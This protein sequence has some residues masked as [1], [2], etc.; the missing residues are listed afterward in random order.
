MFGGDVSISNSAVKN[1]V[2]FE[3]NDENAEYA[4]DGNQ[5]A[6]ASNLPLWKFYSRHDPGGLRYI[7]PYQIG[8]SIGYYLFPVSYLFAIQTTKFCCYYTEYH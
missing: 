8:P 2:A 6:V 1:H 4:N 3:T 5:H 7:V